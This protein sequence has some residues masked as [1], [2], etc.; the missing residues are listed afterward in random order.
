MTNSNIVTTTSNPNPNH[1]RIM[2][3]APTPL[4]TLP[5]PRSCAIV[6]AATD[7]VCCHST[8]TRMKTEAIKIRARAAW[9]TGREGNGLTSCSDPEA[10]V[11]SCQPGNVASRMKQMNARM[12]ATMLNR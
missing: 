10:S 7:A 11:S 8:E 3:D 5:L 12:T 1:P 2:D 6:L 9:E 4:L